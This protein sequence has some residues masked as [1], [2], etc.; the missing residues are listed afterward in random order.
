MKI[1]THDHYYCGDDDYTLCLAC[2]DK[3]PGF[4]GTAFDACKKGMMKE[5][6][7]IDSEDEAE[8][9]EEM[10]YEEGRWEETSNYNRDEEEEVEEDEDEV[11]FE[12]F[13][14]DY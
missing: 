1:V 5:M 12:D 8:E 11:D 10:A 6:G 9:A 7:Y 3:P 13:D 4:V 2:A 14:S